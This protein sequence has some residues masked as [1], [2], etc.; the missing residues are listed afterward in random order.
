MLAPLLVLIV[1]SLFS[2]YGFVKDSLLPHPAQAH[3]AHGLVSM[4]FSTVGITSLAALIAGVG[5]AWVLYRG[6]DKDP[7]NIRLFANKFYFD[8]IYAKLVAIAQDSAAAFMNVIDKLF[9]DGIAVRGSGLAATGVGQLFRRLQVGNIQGY[10]LLFGL[11]VLLVIFL[12]V[13]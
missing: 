10:T 5:L 6:K 7:V 12:A 13:M 8:E 9:I 2:G 1:P 3:E 11:G 4:I